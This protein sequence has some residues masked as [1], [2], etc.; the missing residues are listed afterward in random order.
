V[1]EGDDVTIGCFVNYNWL[2]YLLQYLP[3]VA[4]NITLQ[5]LEDKD[6]LKGPQTPI[7]PPFSAAP[8]DGPEFL[9]TQYK[10]PNVKAGQTIEATCM[11]E[12]LF[13]R[14]RGYSGQNTYALNP[15]NHTCRVQ[16]TVSCEYV[17][18]NYCLLEH[19]FITTPVTAFIPKSGRTLTYRLGI[20]IITI[21][22]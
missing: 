8:Y 12:Y 2:S 4:I 7:V 20:I 17:F 9:Q 15:L 16:H 6:T 5:F 1:V 18:F 22:C 10:I 3:H 19:T 14:T 11:V 13:D 21:I